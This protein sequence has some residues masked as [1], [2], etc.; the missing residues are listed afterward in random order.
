MVVSIVPGSPLAMK[1]VALV[2]GGKDSCYNTMEV[3]CAVLLLR[4]CVAV[5]CC[6]LLCVFAVHC[7]ALLCCYQVLVPC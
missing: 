2:S 3:S 5:R 1:F 7:F 6:A 4:C